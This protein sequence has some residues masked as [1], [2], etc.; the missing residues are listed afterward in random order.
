MHIKN[1]TYNLDMVSIS[2]YIYKEKLEMYYYFYINFT[3]NIKY[4]KIVVI[5]KT[6]KKF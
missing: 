4:Y 1:C 2:H 6:N 5:D 3:F